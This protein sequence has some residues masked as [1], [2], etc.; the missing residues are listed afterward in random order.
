ML[1]MVVE[2]FRDNDM[3]PIYRR[4]QDRG[5]SLSEGLEYMSWVEFKL[6]PLLPVRCSDLRL[7]QKWGL[8]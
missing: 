1:S 2:R 5:R 3:I 4:V 6:C 7:H 8:P